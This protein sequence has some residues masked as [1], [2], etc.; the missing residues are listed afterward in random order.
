[1]VGVKFP[2]G[3]G[4]LLGGRAVD[5]IPPLGPREQYREHRPVALDSH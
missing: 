5:R 2:E 1:V 4:E 3:I